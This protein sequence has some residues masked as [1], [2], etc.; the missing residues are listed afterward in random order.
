MNMEDYEFTRETTSE[1]IAE[2]KAIKKAT[3]TSYVCDD[4]RK[5][6]DDI[7]DNTCIHCLL[8]RIYV[9]ERLFDRIAGSIHEVEDAEA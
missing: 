8:D 9:L 3:R 4:H 6:H 7:P 2:L 5:N 1:I